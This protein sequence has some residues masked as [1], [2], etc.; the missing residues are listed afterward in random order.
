MKCNDVTARFKR[1]DVGIAMEFGRPGIATR[2]GE[3]EKITTAL[4]AVGV[5]F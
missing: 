3:L 1:G 2:L 5:T 4:A